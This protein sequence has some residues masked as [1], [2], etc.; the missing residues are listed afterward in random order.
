MHFGVHSRRSGEAA[1]KV[2]QGVDLV[3]VE[4]GQTG[5]HG[6]CDRPIAIG[7]QRGAG[8]GGPVQDR[9]AAAVVAFE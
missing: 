6:P 3:V 8:D 4:A 1:E 7:E 5:A 2:T 9:F